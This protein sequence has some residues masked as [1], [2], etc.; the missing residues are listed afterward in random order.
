MAA[1]DTPQG[2]LAGK[3]AVVTGA[4]SGMGAAIVRR[5]CAEGARVVA[6]DINA[7]VATVAAEFGDQCASIETDVSSSPQVRA[8]IDLAR[9]RFGRLDILCNNAGIQG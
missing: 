7:G 1:A 9:E 3:V 4:A 8:M 6:A 5:F 2:R